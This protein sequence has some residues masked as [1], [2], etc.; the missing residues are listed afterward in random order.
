[1][2][3]VCSICSDFIMKELNMTPAALLYN[4]GGKFYLLLPAHLQ[5]EVFKARQKINKWLLDDFA[6][7]VFLGLGVTPVTGRMFNEGEMHGAWKAVTED[8]ERDRTRRFRE[9]L[10]PQFFEPEK[11][12]DPTKS[13]SVCGSRS[14]NKKEDRCDT[15]KQLECLGSA[16]R[17]TE[18]ILTLWEDEKEVQH[19]KHDL[20]LN[21]E[22]V[23][24]FPALGAHCLL[25]NKLENRRKALSAIRGFRARC[26][27]LNEFA[28]TSLSSLP[29]PNCALSGMYLGKWESG[30][31]ADSEGNAWDF[32]DYAKNA[33]GIKRSGVLRM[34]VDNLGLI[35]IQGLSF[36][37]RKSIATD[38]GKK[39]GWGEVVRDPESL[40]VIR[41]PMA[42][43]S[44]IVTLSRQLKHFFS[45]YV[46][47]LLKQ[48]AFD[49]CQVIYAGGD[50]LFVIGSWDQLPLLAKTIR[51]E[52]K[53]F[54]C[55]N[56]DF[57]ISGGL[58]LQRGKYPIYKGAQLAGNAEKTAKR[59]RD[60]WHLTSGNEKDA[61][62]F[63]DVPVLWDDFLLAELIKS[64]LETDIQ[65]NS[66]FL[67]F[68]S[69]IAASNRLHVQSLSL[70]RGISAP[71]AW[72]EIEFDAWRW[73]TAYQLRRRY[74]NSSATQRWAELL[75]A[76][77]HNGKESI[78]P[79]Y[80]WLELPLRWTEYLHRKE[81][82]KS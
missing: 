78:L 49:R 53:A 70:Q 12:F 22:R 18:A 68:L 80:T 37:K 35:F 55:D 21:D 8:L 32:E 44:R 38:K 9:F 56:P 66:G 77:K 40:S 15:C 42:S 75:F 45:G 4:S 67:S 10:A 25:I 58:T 69:Q 57:S 74:H 34:D 3:Y 24:S 65:S 51:D 29:I 82:G 14:L 73:R 72:K 5:D 27:F 41:K 43:I 63:L 79:V 81:G 1:V 33:K 62:C 50:D 2:Q 11:D 36:P 59:L 76:G 64:M 26:A 16:L 47:S 17:E 23:L 71:D 30:R 13:C 39:E 6:G 20:D 28:D 31:Q 52:F 54:C 46:P 19:L 48:E 60:Q 61:F 7:E